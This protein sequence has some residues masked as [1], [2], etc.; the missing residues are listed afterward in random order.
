MSLFCGVILCPFKFSNHLTE[1]DRAGC[2]TL[3]MLCGVLC[4]VSLPHG[5]VG[6][7]AVYEYDISWSK[8]AYFV[9]SASSMFES[10]N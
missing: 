8:F 1:E 3:I 7:S 2:Y 4:S 5:A 6:W 10:I 9:A